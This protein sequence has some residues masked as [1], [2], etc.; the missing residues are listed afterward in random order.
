MRMASTGDTV[1]TNN[2]YSWVHYGKKDCLN[3]AN[4]TAR[5]LRRED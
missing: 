3:W 2:T 1:N 4:T 5:M